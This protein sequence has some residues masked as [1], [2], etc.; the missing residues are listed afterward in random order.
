MYLNLVHCKREKN[1]KSTK[2]SNLSIVYVEKLKTKTI[3]LQ[4]NNKI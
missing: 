1:E 2:T 4:Y 3:Q